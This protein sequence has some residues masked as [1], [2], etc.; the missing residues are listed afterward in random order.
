MKGNGVIFIA[1]LIWLV[2]SHIYVYCLHKIYAV[3]L[4]SQIRWGTTLLRVLH[5]ITYRVNVR[6]AI[7]IIIFFFVHKIWQ[8]PDNLKL[9]GKICMIIDN[10]GI[11]K[12]PQVTHWYYTVGTIHYLQRSNIM[13]IFKP[14]LILNPTSRM[15]M[16]SWCVSTM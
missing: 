16:M 9:S 15:D 5:T 11:Y 7:I 14:S 12:V 2:C 3:I 1:C 4:F 13:Y 8:G 10:A 6:V